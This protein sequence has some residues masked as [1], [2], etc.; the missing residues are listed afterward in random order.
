MKKTVITI[1][2]AVFIFATTSILAAAE[3]YTIDASGNYTAL[4]D[5]YMVVD[6]KADAVVGILLKAGTTFSTQEMY[7]ISNGFDTPVSKEQYQNTTLQRKAMGPNGAT[8]IVKKLNDNIDQI[9]QAR[10]RDRQ[11]RR[12]NPEMGERIRRRG[13]REL[14]DFAVDT[15]RRGLDEAFRG[16]FR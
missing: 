10:E 11:H 16:I 8:L 9:S 7:N 12:N 3:V 14:E 2:I 6:L 1:A 5:H 15:I 4:V 13:E